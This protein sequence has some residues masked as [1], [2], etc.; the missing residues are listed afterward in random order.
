MSYEIWKIQKE[1]VMCFFTFADNNF[2]GEGNTSEDE[3]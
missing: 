1:D 3:Y 2:A